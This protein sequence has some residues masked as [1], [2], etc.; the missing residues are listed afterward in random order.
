MTTRLVLLLATAG[1]GLGLSPLSAAALPL[2]PAHDPGKAQIVYVDS[3]EDDDDGW[4]FGFG[5]DDDDDDGQRSAGMR[6]DDDDEG[7]DDDDCGPGRA[8]TP[9]SA[10]PPKNGLFAPG[11]KAQAQIN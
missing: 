10:T 9:Q 6:C 2:L 4:S 11:A 1:F 8:R 7:D 3:D 5:E